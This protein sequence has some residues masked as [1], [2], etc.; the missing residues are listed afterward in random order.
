M[1]YYSKLLTK[2]AS[3]PGE[4]TSDDIE[5]LS[6]ACR[7]YPASAVAA[8]ALL[9][10][11]GSRLSDAERDAL[12]RRVALLGGD[13]D[14]LIAMID[15]SG[16]GFDNFYPTEPI[17]RKPAT[18]SAIDTFLE[19]Y[20]HR[21]PEE[22]ALLER[23]IFNPVPDYA[24]TLARTS[25]SSSAGAPKEGSQDAMIDAFLAAN[26][27]PAIPAAEPEP[28]QA[29]ARQPKVSRQPAAASPQPPSDGLLSESLAKIFIKQ[30]R[31]DRAYEIISNLNL[32][33]PEKSVYFADQLRFLR[34][35]MINQRYAPVK[36]A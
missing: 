11:G 16:R 3:A 14:N 35:L 13:R 20:G 25:P 32:N 8:A 31:Y 21:T 30:G 12:R 6:R 27:A 7:E 33:Y 9:K 10:Y 23:M 4:L 2:I 22:D 1:D 28:P 26:P 29:P 36:N 17:V 19:T 24:E 15:P 34:K 18:E 5:A